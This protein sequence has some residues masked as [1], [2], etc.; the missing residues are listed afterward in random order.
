[1]SI[2]SLNKS[3]PSSP[4]T[5]VDIPEV[6][7]FDAKFYYNFFVPDE[8][9]NEN[10]LEVFRGSDDINQKLM[11]DVPRMIWFDFRPVNIDSMG[12]HNEF[13]SQQNF[14]ETN[15]PSIEKNINKIRAE[16]Q[17]TTTQ[18][19]GL[20]FQD[21]NIDEKLFIITSG[22]ISRRVENHNKQLQ[23]QFNDTLDKIDKRLDRD[24]VNL[25]DAAKLLSTG[26]GNR[27]AQFIVQALNSL[28]NTN[29]KFIS[30]V[31]QQDM[32]LRRFEQIRDVGIDVQI[33]SKFA[34]AML[35]SIQ[36]D[37]FG[38]FIDEV[39]PV[40]STIKQEQK[41]A[42]SKFN[43]SIIKSSEYD[44]FADPIN[45]QKVNISTF[46]TRR[47]IV[48]YIIDKVEISADG[49]IIN[50]KPI[51]LENP[52]AT[53]AVDVD[54]AY[55]RKYIYTIRTIAE[56]ELVATTDDSDDIVAASI[57]ISSKPSK[58]RVISSIEEIPP[59]PPVDFNVDWDKSARAPRL[60]WSFP[61]NPQRD[62]KKWQI[63][64]RASIN[65]PFELIKEYDFDDSIIK[66]QSGERPVTRLIE[67]M[68]SPK[69]FYIDYNFDQGE[70][71]I[72]S[73]CAI[74]AHGMTS[75]YSMQYEV[76]FD[77]AQNRIYKTLISSSGAPKPYPN[78]FVTQEDV[79]VDVLRDSGHSQV[80]VY[81]DPEFLEVT[82]ADKNLNLLTTG[83]NGGMYRMQ[84]I[85]TDLQQGAV[86]DIILNDRRRPKHSQA[87]TKP[88]KPRVKSLI[89]K[90]G[91][92]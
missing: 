86:L 34:D 56:I 61:I 91:R 37:P 54:I 69:N 38:L 16:Q 62:I 10:G 42:L 27:D 70:K 46:D 74:D 19:I 25:F 67:R 44:I 35:Q 31:T 15:S 7:K 2:L 90:S 24:N 45:T 30:Q 12:M 43:A 21:D 40:L 14:S 89:T 47:R 88:Q 82:T 78:M 64:K 87:P 80:D 39:K 84:L 51:I 17:L 75:N 83:K 68:T 79:L 36:T 85:N 20:R 53:N 4:A 26:F 50:K 59:S 58:R 57:L 48:G 77:S 29:A 76:R 1:M 5:F 33:N 18:F 8:S 81:F 22:A 71:C 65:V 66:A 11:R 63:F 49:S 13:R 73:L 92:V 23:R 52:G 41:R 32:L 9:I 55:G 28:K 3:Y 72:Y 6:T 60:V